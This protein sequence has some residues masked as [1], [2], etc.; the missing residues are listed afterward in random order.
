MRWTP[1]CSPTARTPPWSRS[2]TGT[3]RTEISK[4]L[5]SS[6]PGD[7]P[8]NCVGKVAG[9]TS[10]SVAP[11]R[12]PHAAFCCLLSAETL[13]SRGE[14]IACPRPRHPAHG[15]TVRLRLRWWR[16]LAHPLCELRRD[17]AERQHRHRLPR[18]Y[19]QGAI[20]L[21]LQQ[22]GHRRD[23]GGD[24]QEPARRYAL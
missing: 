20:D 12:L 10:R 13:A 8:L 5:A 22:Q 2:R 1:G 23:Q 11:E 15:R 16:R 18:L 3:S 7:T 21:H 19:L 9:K 17:P 24:G 6:V 14:S 4:G